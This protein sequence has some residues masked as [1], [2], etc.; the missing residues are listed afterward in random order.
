MAKADLALINGHIYTIDQSES[1]VEAVACKNERIVF[2]GNMNEVESFID[3]NTKVID[4]HGKTVLPGLIDSH[5]HVPGNAYN[6]LY[7]INL[8][9]AKTDKETTDAIK[10]FVSV[11]PERDIY[12]GRGFMSAVFGGIESGKGPRKER[13]DEICPDKPII[14]VDYGGHVVWL[15]SKA[16]AEFNI[17]KE[18]PGVPG[19]IIEKDPDTG[20]LWGV[21]KEEAKSLYPQ[22]Q[23]NIEEKMKA[24]KWMQGMLH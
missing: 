19:G 6:V 22:Q 8:F 17:T 11:N 24:V 23:F 18:T 9:D 2:V 21:L 16:L 4:L 5:L 3:S 20:E 7:N 13:L 10:N 14:L 15:N 12:Y 1:V